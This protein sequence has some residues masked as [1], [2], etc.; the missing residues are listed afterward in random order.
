MEAEKI[1]IAK[2]YTNFLGGPAW[3]NKFMRRNGLSIRTVTTTGQS[4]PPGWEEKVASFH[5]FVNEKKNGIQLCQLA[6]M[7]EVPMC[8]DSP[9]SRTVEFKGVEDVAIRTTGHE[10]SSFSLILCV[11]AEGNK[12]PPMVIFKRKTIPKE[13]FPRGIVVYANEKGWNNTEMMTEWLDKVWR[14]RPGGFFK[15]KSLLILDSAT[16]HKTDEVKNAIKKHSDIAMIPGG[17]T[18]K[19]QPLD[20]TVNKSFKSKIRRKW[21][22]WMVKDEEHT[23][24][25]NNKQR[26]ASYSLVC[27]WIV[28]CWKEIT[29][30]CIKNGFRK[31]GIQTYDGMDTIMEEETREIDMGEDEE[32]EL[33]GG[34]IVVDLNIEHIS[35]FDEATDEDI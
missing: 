10:K 15:T 19:L 23:F 8:F 33:D 25:K 28:D 7:D 4:L 17:L 24:T 27:K 6:N 20:L 13:E 16:C 18:K 31:S 14:R 3:C 22:D 12:L 29:P 5:H 34:E 1:A 11:T 21:E 30:E 32:F 35:V 9:D 26:R 2:G